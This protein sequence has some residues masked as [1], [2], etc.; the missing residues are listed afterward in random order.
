M[1]IFML[2]RSTSGT[3]RPI[4]VIRTLAGFQVS[5]MNVGGSGADACNVSPDIG[6]DGLGV[7]N[8]MADARNDG[9][10]VCNIRHGGVLVCSILV[11]IGLS[12][13]CV[14]EF[15]LEAGG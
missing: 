4:F 14:P 8:V 15:S 1:N 10:S 7:W 2:R 11:S 5:T 12:Y 3:Y 9:L 6:N 13:T